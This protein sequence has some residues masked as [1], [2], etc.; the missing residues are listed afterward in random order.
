MDGFGQ[1]ATD[2][3][4]RQI[5]PTQTHFGARVGR[6]ILILVSYNAKSGMEIIIFLKVATLHPTK[7]LHFLSGTILTSN[8]DSFLFIEVARLFRVLM[9]MGRSRSRIDPR[10]VA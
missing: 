7:S 4:H 10:C 3:Y 8:Y 6:K 2:V 5:E 9:A 1:M